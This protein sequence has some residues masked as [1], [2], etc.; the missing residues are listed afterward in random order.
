MWKL[1]VALLALV[2]T[3]LL[4]PG[5]VQATTAADVC[6]AADD[7]CELKK[8][9]TVD[10]DSTLD[11][12]TRAFVIRAPDGRLQVDTAGTLT[13]MAGSMLVETGPGGR[14]R[15]APG[16]LGGSRVA[17][18]VGGTFAVERLGFPT[19]AIDVSSNAEPCLLDI[20][21]GGD[22]TIGAEINAH[23]G[24]SAGEVFIASAGRVTIS[25][26]ILADS[27]LFGGAVGVKATG[28]I[29]L[30]E[31][32]IIDA[33]DA[34]GFG[35][36]DLDTDADLLNAGRLV[37][38]ARFSEFFGCDGGALLIE[39]LGDIAINGPI[40]GDGNL[41]GCVGG[42]LNM[43]AGRDILVNARVDFSGGPNGL[44]G[45]IE[46]VQAGRDFLQTAPI[47]VRSGGLRGWGGE[48]DIVATRHL[49]VG[50]VLDLSGG[51]QIDP[52]TGDLGRGGNLNLTA[53]DTLE[54]VAEIAADGADFGSLRFTTTREATDEMPGRIVLTGT[55]H[56][57][58]SAD[59]DESADVLFE[60]CDI[61][62][63][64]SGSVEKTGPASR[65]LLRASNTMKIAGALVAGSGTNELHHRDLTKPPLLLPTA[66]V[67]PPPE[68]VATPD[69]PLPPC[70]CT[71]DPAAAGLLCDDG[72]A[73]T[74]E[75]CVPAVGCTSTPLAGEGVAGCDD[76]N[77][78]D[79]RETCDALV[80][81]PGPVPAPDDG[82]PC[83]D[84]GTC[85]PASGYPRTPKTGFGAVTCRMER[86]QNA[87][88]AANVPGDVSAKSLKKIKRLAKRIRSSVERATTA[89]R[90][91]RAQ[92]L[93]A[94]AGKL[95]R[96]D[97]VIASPKTSI[98]PALSQFLT[99][100]TSGVRSALNQL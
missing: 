65:N 15:N 54:I 97:G 9:I 49:L 90:R 31:D 22:V 62:I 7:P 85:D 77:A 4:G 34:I 57:L 96:L 13:I 36:I 10:P 27:G 3:A 43:L 44:G 86:I 98:S 32:G 51:A 33:S 79:G 46:Q 39:A 48:V 37:V 11:F 64:A 35:S 18:R 76:G 50:A 94:A 28:P 19:V 1:A 56:A 84:D 38:K 6:G 80:C 73:C 14:L 93:G 8:E 70:A 63:A 12:G 99:A 17:I 25:D 78:C 61:E 24:E 16:S 42:T 74:Q 53:V 100:E 82:D 30:T 81:H 5:I 75:A 88:T 41:E 40:S 52:D 58:A 66:V 21:A 47:V 87:L 71:L 89:G 20:N 91:R 26:G 55:V 83:T 68:I 23:G 2:A 92:L 59:E 29:E 67:S 60:A 45:S 95:K 69:E 72:N